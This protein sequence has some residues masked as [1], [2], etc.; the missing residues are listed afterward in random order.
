MT[1]KMV[2]AFLAGIITGAVG[3]LLLAPKSGEELREQMRAT[4]DA[5]MRRL[6]SEWQQNMEQMQGRLDKIHGDM[7]AMMAKMQSQKTADE[8][9]SSGE[10]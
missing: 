6:R 5:D 7:S 3:A 2:A 8:G 9:T 4:V 10:S 1:I